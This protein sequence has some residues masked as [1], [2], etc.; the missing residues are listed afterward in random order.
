MTQKISS[1]PSHEIRLGNVRATIWKNESEGVVRYNVTFIRS[2][3]DG[4]T[5]KNSDSYGRDDLPRVIKC[6]D[7]AYEWIFANTG[8]GSADQEGN[9]GGRTQSEG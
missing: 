5:W 9:S 8:S 6:S 2:Y 4:G 7:L 1:K 3:N